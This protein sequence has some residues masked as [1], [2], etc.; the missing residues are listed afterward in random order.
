MDISRALSSFFLNEQNKQRTNSTQSR[1]KGGGLIY[2]L[3]SPF[4][5]FFYLFALQKK[6]IEFDNYVQADTCGWV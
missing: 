4:Y 2:N 1:E 5:L 6:G 3:L